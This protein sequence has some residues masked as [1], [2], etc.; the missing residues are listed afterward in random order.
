MKLF[1]TFFLFITV[2]NTSVLLADDKAD[3]NKYKQECEKGDVEEC[4]SLGVLYH[5]GEG[6]KQNYLMANKYYEQ[7]CDGGYAYG[8]FNLGNSY[9]TGKGMKQDR[10]MAIKLYTK[11]CDGGIDD[12]CTNL[13]SMYAEVDD[14]LMAS[15]YYSKACANEFP[16]ACYKLGAMNANG[17]FVLISYDKALSFYKK[18]CELGS[19]KDCNKFK[20]IYEADK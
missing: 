6:V 9:Y 7:A 8:C 2:F 12:S 11:A 4:N 5:Y 1:I 18:E 17:E 10:Q 16:A 3:F 20:I 19:D 15:K 13:G 14:Y